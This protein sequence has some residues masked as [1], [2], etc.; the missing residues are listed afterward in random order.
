M[1]PL[2]TDSV[3]GSTPETVLCKSLI[4]SYQIGKL[5][6]NPTGGL[7]CICLLCMIIRCSGS[8]HCLKKNF[9]SFLLVRE[10]GQVFL[11]LQNQ[12]LMIDLS[13]PTLHKYRRKVLEIYRE[14]ERN[15]WAPLGIF[16]SKLRKINILNSKIKNVSSDIGKPEGEYSNFT[17][18]NHVQYGLKKENS[19]QEDTYKEDSLG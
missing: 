6:P 9:D 17:N 7:L 16:E 12:W 15:P 13:E 8:K 18:D 2:S 4:H 19:S 1:M 5:G 10:D 3:T 11:K 14:L